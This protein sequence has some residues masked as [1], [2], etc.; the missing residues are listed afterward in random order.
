MKRKIVTAVA[1]VLGLLTILSLR[2]VCSS[3]SQ[4]Q[5]GHTSER[6]A[7]KE[8]DPKKKQVALRRAIQ[9]YRRAARWYAPGNGYVTRALDALER[10]GRL[11]EKRGDRPTALMCYRA[12]R[13]AILGARSFYTPHEERLGPTNRRIARLSARIQG[14]GKSSARIAQYEA[15]HLKQLRKNTAPSVGWTL[16][17]LLGFVAWV[18]GA[19]LFIFRAITP[20]DQLISR[21]ALIWGGVILAGL[22]VWLLGLWQA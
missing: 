3:R 10:L 21:Q 5:L 2:V 11:A 4:Y 7:L 16:L 20:E 17:A 1:I 8:R 14:Q 18:G 19:F 12:I 9:H 6:Q 13:R 15:W 22:L